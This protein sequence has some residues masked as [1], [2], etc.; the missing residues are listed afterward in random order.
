ME[1]HPDDIEYSTSKLSGYKLFTDHKSI[2]PGDHYRLT[3]NK[4]MQSGR[5]CQYVVVQSVDAEGSIFVNR[6][7]PT[8]EYQFPDW[9][10]RLD[11]KFREIRLYKKD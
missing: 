2:K 6:Y 9:K 11:C 4:Y 10:L 3:Q 1:I 5:K 8:G 7:S